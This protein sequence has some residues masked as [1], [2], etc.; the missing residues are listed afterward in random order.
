MFWGLFSAAPLFEHIP[1][2]GIQLGEQRVFS[3]VRAGE[4][5]TVAIWI[6]E[7]DRVEYRMICD[8]QNVNALGF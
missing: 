2:D 4:F 5:D 8:P 6:K 7:V 3:W 1:F